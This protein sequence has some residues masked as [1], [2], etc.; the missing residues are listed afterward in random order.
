M[1]RIYNKTTFILLIIVLILSVQLFRLESQK[2]VLKSDLIEL[3]KAK[4]GILD[5]NEWKEVLAEAVTQKISDFQL[6]DDEKA[7]LREELIAFLTTAAEGFEERYY[8]EKMRSFGGVFQSL[9]A[10][11]TGAFGKI[12]RDIPIFAD[13]I[14]ATLEQ[15]QGDSGLKRL[16]L[17]KFDQYLAETFGTVDYTG[18]LQVLNKYGNKDDRETRVYLKSELSTINTTSQYYRWGILVSVLL[19]CVYLLY[20][21]AI[22][23]SEITITILIS[24]LLLMSGILLPMIDIDAR[25]DQAKISFIGTE[26]AF[27]DQVL[28]YRSKSILEV[29]M[30]MFAQRKLD[31]IIVGLLILLFS[32]IFPLSKLIASV[33]YLYSATAKRNRIVRFL[34]FQTGKWSMAD[35]MVVAIFMAFIGF[36]GVLNEQLTQISELGGSDMLTTN[37]SSLQAGFYLFTAFVVLSL[38]TSTQMKKVIH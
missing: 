20:A 2:R 16:I 12:K 22:R 6:N 8:D 21:K 10:A 25:I 14:I 36:R 37:H 11:T 38:M 19:I 26:I 3:S 30:L 17:G 1:N 7:L 9:L 4:Y 35:V 13:Q 24:L 18:K 23:K 27:Y 32:V 33:S 5:V 28:Y 15:S 29:V 34:V 31:V